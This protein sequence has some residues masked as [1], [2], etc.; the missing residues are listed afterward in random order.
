MHSLLFLLTLAGGPL[1]ANQLVDS[2]Y[3]FQTGTETGTVANYAMNPSILQIRPG[4]IAVCYTRGD[5]H[6]SGHKTYLQLTEDGGR[7]WTSPVMIYDAGTNAFG[8]EH[9]DRGC[10]FSKLAGSNRIYHSVNINLVGPYER[11]ALAPGQHPLFPNGS[12]ACTGT[13]AWPPGFKGPYREIR[14]RYTDDLFQTWSPMQVEIKTGGWFT[15]EGHPKIVEWG[16]YCGRFVYLKERGDQLYQVDFARAAI[17]EGPA[18]VGPVCGEQW[19]V[20]LVARS[21]LPDHNRGREY[22]EPRP[23]LDPDDALRVP[24]NPDMPRRL[25]VIRNDK[26][27]ATSPDRSCYLSTSDDDGESWDSQ[28]PYGPVEVPSPWV[29]SVGPTTGRAPAELHFDAH[30]QY[31]PRY[32]FPCWSA[33]ECRVVA[34]AAGQP[35]VVVGPYRD[36]TQG[37]QPVMRASTDG[38]ATFGPAV[39][40]SLPG[41]VGMTLYSSTEELSR[42]GLGV[43]LAQELASSQGVPSDTRTAMSFFTIGVSTF[44]RVQA[45]E[46]TSSQPSQP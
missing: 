37:D 45:L 19:T 44:Y 23:C 24:G 7:T 26:F 9:G 17:V 12:P 31:Q 5:D 4:L 6:S 3:M 27:H 32:L 30:P 35:V 2:L 13:C 29:L 16:G 38:G 28:P 21:A 15:S 25:V 20:E 42:G 36:P 18:G 40:V 1:G 22:E 39:L 41:A 34:G 11:P 33:P 14:D 43:V 8:V 10:V 46:E